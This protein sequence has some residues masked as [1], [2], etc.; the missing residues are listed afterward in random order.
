MPVGLIG[1]GLQVEREFM[2]RHQQEEVAR[3]QER[4][5]TRSRQAASNPSDLTRERSDQTTRSVLAARCSVM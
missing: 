5:R 4:E 2:Q 3:E 1:Y